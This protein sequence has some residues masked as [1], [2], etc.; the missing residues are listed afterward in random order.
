MGVRGELFSTKVSL[1]NRTYFFNVKENRLGDL[2]LN[3][4]ESKNR[5]EGGFE[6]Q[7]VILFAED[8]QDFL[9]G[10]DESLRVLEKAAREKKKGFPKKRERT[11]NERHSETPFTAERSFQDGPRSADRQRSGERPR[12]HERTRSNDRPRSTERARS[13][14]RPRPGDRQWFQ[15]GPRSENGS[16]EPGASRPGRKPGGRAAGGGR[17]TERSRTG[18]KTSEHST[19]FKGEG[20]RAR[21]PRE[22]SEFP[23]RKKRVVVKKR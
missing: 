3:I 22:K 6:R 15:D 8:L 23:P 18:G 5:D 10:F 9:Q 17:I 7:S 4:V 19:G 20:S 2:Y 12:F 13:T 11:S 1:Q 21:R 14:G 16:R